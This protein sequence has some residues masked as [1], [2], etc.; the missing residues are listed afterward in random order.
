MAYLD[1]A[2]DPLSNLENFED[3]FTNPASMQFG[4]VPDASSSEPAVVADEP[5][6]G[7]MR[8]QALRGLTKGTAEELHLRNASRGRPPSLPSP[9][10]NGDEDI[11]IELSKQPTD[12]RLLA[13]EQYV[14]EQHARDIF[15]LNLKTRTLENKMTIVLGETDI[16]GSKAKRYNMST[17]SSPAKTELDDDADKCV[18]LAGGGMQLCL[19]V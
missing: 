14:F 9:S 10:S 12:Q 11:L 1:A 15:S 5:G 16:V 3:P 17:F 13:L 2:K 19:V 6:T 8:S 7:P 4:I 18:L